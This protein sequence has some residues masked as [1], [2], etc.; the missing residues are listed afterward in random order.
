MPAAFELFLPCRQDVVSLQTHG[1]SLFLKAPTRHPVCSAK[2]R[3]ESNIETI[4]IVFKYFHSNC[5]NCFSTGMR[6]L[7]RA[8]F[9]AALYLNDQRHPVPAAVSQRQTK[10]VSVY[11]ELIPHSFKT[12]NTL[13]IRQNMQLF[14]FTKSADGAVLWRSIQQESAFY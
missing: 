6:C 5:S 1:R 3:R 2:K 12:A 4:K 13:R 8:Q 7:S 9:H 11:H 10:M 14:L